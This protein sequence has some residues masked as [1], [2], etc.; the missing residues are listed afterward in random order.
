MTLC[1]VLVYLVVRVITNS[2]EFYMTMQYAN[3]EIILPIALL[4]IFLTIP[5]LRL[6]RHVVH[7]LIQTELQI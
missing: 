2:A 6:G 7:R 3:K 5:R 4:C 1:N